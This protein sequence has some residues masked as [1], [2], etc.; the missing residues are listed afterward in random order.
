MPFSPGASFHASIIPLDAC[1]PN[2]RDASL[3]IPC[4]DSAHREVCLVRIITLVVSVFTAS[5]R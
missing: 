3:L 2:D 5:V 4:T 1:S